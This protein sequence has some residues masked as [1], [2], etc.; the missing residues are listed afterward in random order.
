MSKDKQP[1]QKAPEV[2]RLAVAVSRGADGKW[3]FEDLRLTG[4]KVTEAKTLAALDGNKGV[5]VAA[6][7]MLLTTEE[8]VQEWQRQGLLK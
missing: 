2:T 6:G 7:T 3:L 1:E 4:D 5:R 8:R